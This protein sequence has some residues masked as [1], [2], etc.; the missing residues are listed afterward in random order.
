MLPYKML[1][2]NVCKNIPEVKKLYDKEIEEDSL[3]DKSGVH[4]VFSFC[5]VP[6]LKEAILNDDEALVKK[7]FNYIED[8][9]KSSDPL[10]GEVAEFTIL[11][12][13]LD[14]FNLR[15]VKKYMGENT[16]QSASLIN[17]Y[18]GTK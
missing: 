7:L 15:T 17:R 10:V 9:E 11:E 3:D 13:L 8:M 4:T 6:V 1:I 14:D 16:L 18:I 2:E 5:F 12:E